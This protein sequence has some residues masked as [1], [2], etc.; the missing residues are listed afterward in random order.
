MINTSTFRRFALAAGMLFAASTAQATT[1]VELSTED[2]AHLSDVIVVAEIKDV[3]MRDREGRIWTHNTA[4]VIDV[5]KGD[6]KVGDRLNVLE[7]G[8]VM[9]DRVMDVPGTAGYLKNERVV[10]FLESKVDGGYNTIGLR[11]G[12][13]TLASN[14]AGGWV[15][16]N[17]AVS[18]YERGSA[19]N[20]KRH[21]KP[22]MIAR[23]ADLA[24]LATEVKTVVEADRKAGI[25]GRDLP[26]YKGFVR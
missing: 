13:K 12:K 1:M 23:G 8:G 11:Q 14:G 3:Q 10:L 5:W 2:L 20:A 18:V 4:S 25:R 26:K 16:T 24:T 6:V 17:V 19:F 15:V 22:E 7:M 21:V 9:G